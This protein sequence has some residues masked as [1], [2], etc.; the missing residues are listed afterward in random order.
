MNEIV[1]NIL[2]ECYAKAE[3]PLDFEKVLDNPE[4]YPKFYKE[5]YLDAD[6]HKAII[7]KHLEKHD[8]TDKEENAIAVET[9]LNYGPTNRKP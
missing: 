9:F 7:E 2:I 5:H 4:D 1:K 8:L 6:E 3:P